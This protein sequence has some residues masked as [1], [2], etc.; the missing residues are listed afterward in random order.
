MNA[1]TIP[2]FNHEEI[3]IATCTHPRGEQ[4]A[5]H[6]DGSISYHEANA[7]I[8][9]NEGREP[10]AILTAEGDFDRSEWGIHRDDEEGCWHVENM[11]EAWDDSD[12]ALKA[13]IA[14]FGLP[15]EFQADLDRRVQEAAEQD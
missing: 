10:V 14:E 1:I 6:T 4:I 15:A 3:Y 8:I 12:D 11:N 5:I 7:R 9:W 2:E 13:A